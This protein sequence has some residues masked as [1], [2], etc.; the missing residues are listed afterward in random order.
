MGHP[1]QLE[2]E[3]V[4]DATPDRVWEAIATGPGL[5]SWFLGHNQVDPRE[6]GTATLDMG[7]FVETSTITT[8]DPPTRFVSE[9][10]PG[11]DGAFHR[12]DYSVDVRDDGRTNVRWVHS[13]MLGDDWEREYE[14]M[15]EGDP[16]YFRQLLAYVTYFPGRFG[17]PI[18]ATGPNVAD[19]KDAVMATFR[20]GLGLAGDVAVGDEV[21]ATPHGLP[22]IHGVVDE[23]SPSFLG[24][25]TDDGFYRFIRG[26]EG[27]VVVG[28]HLFGDVDEERVTENWGAW[29]ARTFAE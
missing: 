29:L 8:W 16:M 26:Y 14:G 1:F 6:G 11:P 21:H 17:T 24:I 2:Y 4:V 5:D 25:R 7:G 27:T 18:T 13:G 22:P 10:A 28:H 15:S 9:G 12:F 19:D 23:T 3:D 20:R